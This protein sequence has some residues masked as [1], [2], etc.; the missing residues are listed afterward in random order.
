MAVIKIEVED[1]ELEELKETAKK[2]GFSRLEDYIKYILKKNRLP[3]I[4]YEGSSRKYKINR[5]TRDSIY[6]RF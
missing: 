2:Y 1:K 4:F 5:I 6:D 3:S